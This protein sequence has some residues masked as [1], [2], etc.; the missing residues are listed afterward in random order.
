MFVVLLIQPPFGMG[1]RGFSVMDILVVVGKLNV[2]GSTWWLFSIYMIKSSSLVF[3]VLN[4]QLRLFIQ[5][6]S[7]GH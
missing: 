1:Y 2:D 3:M 5:N 4:K 7:L 6:N